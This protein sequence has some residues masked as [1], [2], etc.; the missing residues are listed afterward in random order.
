MNKKII[1]IA[2]VAV[3]LVAMGVWEFWGR[4]AVTTEEI[5]VL[6]EPLAANVV[7]KK[8]DFKLKKVEA[9]SKNALRAADINGIIG[10]RTAQYVAEDTELRREYFAQSDYIIGEDT[11]KALMSLSTDWLISYPKTM[12]RG[13]RLTLYDGKTKVGDVVVAHVRDSGNNEVVFG[14][15]D[16]ESATGV[17]INIDVIS[18]VATLLGI[19]ELAKAGSKFALICV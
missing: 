17:I 4:A 10:L 1:G 3:A 9:P 12:A 7:L 6:R 11:G 5:L 16:R 13:D 18:D 8:E 15:R 19:A 14:G 2:I